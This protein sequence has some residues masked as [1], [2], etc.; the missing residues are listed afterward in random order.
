[1]ATPALVMVAGPNGSGK[2]T[3]I[4]KLRES[5]V[6]D[7]PARYVN[8]DEL[9][10]ARGLATGEAQKLAETLRREAIQLGHSVMYET[11]M[12]HPSKIAELQAAARQGYSITVLF[13]ATSSPELNVQRVKDR[14]AE[15]GHDVPDDK[16]RSRYARA[17]ALAP[18]A[19]GYANQALVF[20]NSRKEGHA[21]HAELIG[22]RL[23][24]TLA[25]L[26]PWTRKIVAE[27]NER[28]AEIEGLIAGRRGGDLIA[29]QL[30]SGEY[31]G[32][33]LTTIARH[34]V[35]QIDDSSQAQIIHDRA[36]LAQPLRD[37]ESCRITYR[38]GVAQVASVRR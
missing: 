37:H 36:L 24:P 26:L 13:V 17:L 1:M 10:R 5:G 31:L 12:S 35:L 21:L 33:V 11:V 3:L 23:R 25:E 15:G 7:L 34:F 38:D 27:V 19:I 4:Q 29:A 14:V 9:Q 6:A 8:A 18:S 20:D 32:P 16:T 2:S 28:S 22:G 30:S